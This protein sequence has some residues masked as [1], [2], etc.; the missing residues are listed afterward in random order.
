MT[1]DGHYLSLLKIETLLDAMS[2]WAAPSAK[3]G[4]KK[5]I[6]RAAAVLVLWLEIRGAEFEPCI[7]SIVLRARKRAGAP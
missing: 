6:V 5:R 7:L 1:A 3:A 4:R 2:D